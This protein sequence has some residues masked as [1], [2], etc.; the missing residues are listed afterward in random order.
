[1]S[2]P[3]SLTVAA[4]DLSHKTGSN[5]STTQRSAIDV[6][7]TDPRRW[8]LFTDASLTKGREFQAYLQHC[9][10]IFS[11]GTK[12]PKQTNN[13]TLISFQKVMKC[14]HFEDVL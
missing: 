1:M 13:K 8:P 12:N 11:S 3:N 4:T 2:H 5:S 10:G 14:I 9:S 7:I 6:S